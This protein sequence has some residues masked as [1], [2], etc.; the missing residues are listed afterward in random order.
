MDVIGLLEIYKKAKAGDKEAIKLLIA[1]ME[2][3]D[4]LQYNPSCILEWETKLAEQGDATACGKLFS[5]VECSQ[6]CV[7]IT[8]SPSYLEK[9]KEDDSKQNVRACIEEIL[10]EAQLEG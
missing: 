3:N 8:V 7:P 5:L 10:R 6:D 9:E 4:I 1:N 2:S